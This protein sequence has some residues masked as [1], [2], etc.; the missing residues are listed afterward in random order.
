MRNV[1]TLVQHGRHFDPSRDDYYCNLYT[2]NLIFRTEFY[3]PLVPHQGGVVVST[4]LPTGK[5]SLGEDPSVPV[6]LVSP[7]RGTI[8]TAADADLCMVAAGGASEAG[9]TIDVHVA[10]ITDSPKHGK[11]EV[12]PLDIAGKKAR[13]L[14]H[15]DDGGDG[16]TA[17]AGDAPCALGTIYVREKDTMSRTELAIDTSGG[18]AIFQIR[19]LVPAA[20]QEQQPASK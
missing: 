18:S 9:N 17:C 2:Q 5:K 3:V 13:I 20:K 10:R 7:S 4:F 19:N 11:F 12:S 14:Y 6:W 1:A 8:C 16:L 15:S